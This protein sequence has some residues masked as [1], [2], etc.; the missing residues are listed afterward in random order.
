MSACGGLLKDA[1]GDFI[2]NCD[3]GRNNSLNIE[4]WSIVHA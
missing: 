2:H 1:Q 4:M 3:F